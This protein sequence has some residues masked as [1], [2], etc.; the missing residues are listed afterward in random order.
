M[1]D[2]FDGWLND[3]V[4]DLFIDSIN[5][6]TTHKYPQD[7]PLYAVNIFR[8]IQLFKY[9]ECSPFNQNR[10]NIHNVDFAKIEEFHKQQFNDIINCKPH[11]NLQ[12]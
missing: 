3:E 12:I 11:E 4:R 7:P 9:G 8:I 6:H 10:L 2:R 5:L 1:Q